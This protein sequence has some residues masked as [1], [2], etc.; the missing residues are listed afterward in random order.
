MDWYLEV[1]RKYATFT[2]RARRKEYWFFALFNLLIMLVLSF[3]DGMIGLYS[4]E[5][6]LGVLSG[7]YTLAVLIPSLAVTVR[8]L[9]DIGR[10]G[11]WLLIAFI[12]L[13]GALILLIFTVLDSK[14]GSNQYGPDPKGMDGET[15]VG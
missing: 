11:W 10:S 6:G 7:I 15:L 3:I 5:A 2:G 12:P 1:L 8:R 9:H 4:I 13:I 14:P